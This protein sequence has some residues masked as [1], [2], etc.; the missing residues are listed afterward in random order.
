MGFKIRASQK[1]DRLGPTGGRQVVYVVWIETE[2][3]STGSIEIDA[4]DFHSDRL[5]TL[6]E[7]EAIDL[8]RPFLVSG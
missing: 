4:D 6:L 8:D 1:Q 3:G 7:A 2:R 5:K